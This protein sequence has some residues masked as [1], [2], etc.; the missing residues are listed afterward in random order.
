MT[1]SVIVQPVLSHHQCPSR[2]ISVIG[3]NRD[4]SR[5]GP[6]IDYSLSWQV[7]EATVIMFLPVVM[8]LC[9]FVT[10]AYTPEVV[11]GGR[12]TQTF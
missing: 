7:P 4:D 6:L 8:M 3:G 11:C 2:A 12:S 1:G 10:N 9:Y 5:T